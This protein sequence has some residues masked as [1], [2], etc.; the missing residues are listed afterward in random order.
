ML[1]INFPVVCLV[2]FGLMCYELLPWNVS[3]SICMG[4][5][6]NETK[7]KVLH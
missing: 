4:F 1:L 2:L 5:K 3:H 7:N 6:T